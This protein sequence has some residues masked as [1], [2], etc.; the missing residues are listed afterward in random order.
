MKHFEAKMHYLLT[1][2]SSTVQSRLKEGQGWRAAATSNS[3]Q[4]SSGN[5]A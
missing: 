5:E 4:S 1:P 2:Y 3:T